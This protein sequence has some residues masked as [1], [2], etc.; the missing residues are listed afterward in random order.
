[1]KA[2]NLSWTKEETPEE[3]IP[4]LNMLGEDYPIIEASEGIKLTF[5]RQDN[6][7]K[8]K[9]QNDEAI[10]NYDS[11]SSAARG[12]GTV[13]SGIG[14]NSDEICEQSPFET[15][16]ILFECSRNAIPTVDYFKQWLK[17]LALMGCNLAMLYTKD[18]YELPGEDYFGYLRGR[19]NL[20]E[21]REIDDYASKLGIEMIGCIQALGHLEPVLRWPVYASIKDTSSVLLTTEEKSYELVDKMMEFYSKAFK[22]RRIHLGMDE[23]HDLGRGAYMDKN[24]YRR[25]FDIYNDHL[26]RIS[27]MCGK[28]GLSYMI[29][30]DMYFRM[31]SNTQ[32][33]Y[34]TEAVIPDDVKEKIPKDAQLVYWDYYHKDEDFYVEWIKRHKA[35]GFPPFMA[36]GVWTWGMLWHNQKQTEDTVTPCINACI[37]ENVKEFVLTAW[38][39]DGMLCDFDSAQAGVCYAAEKAFAGEN[40]NEENASKRFHAICGGDYELHKKVSEITDMEENL[41]SVFLLWDDPL[42]GIYW[43]NQEAPI[44]NF[45]KKALEKYSEIG[46]LLESTEEGKAGDIQRIRKFVKFLRNKIDFKLNLEAAYTQKNNAALEELKERIP[47]IISEIDDVIAACRIHWNKRYKSFGFEFVHVRL[48]GQ[49]ERFNEL[50]IRLDELISGK[51]SSIPELEEK[52]HYHNSGYHFHQLATGSYFI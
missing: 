27:E 21:L 48:G 37:K 45:W 40:Y 35:L 12:I 31:G 20:E 50:S 3:L 2:Q 6:G 39:D 22:S 34:D 25:G 38:G 4:M 18:A 42:L 41:R 49:K 33:Y 28:H 1:M 47:E 10:I 52:A 36:S 11:I 44:E 43:K 13:L 8:I 9:H 7:L 17:R 51:I 23:T 30:S 19:Y 14:E 32:G 26:S 16:G 24:G 15:F 5:Q 46:K 29:W